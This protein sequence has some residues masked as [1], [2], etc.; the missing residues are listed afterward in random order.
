MQRVGKSLGIAAEKLS[1]EQLEAVP[2][3][4]KGGEPADD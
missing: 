2:D 4:K 3:E 1:K